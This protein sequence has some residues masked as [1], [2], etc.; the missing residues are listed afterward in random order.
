VRPL[1]LGLILALAIA[2]QRPWTPLRRSRSVA[3]IVGLIPAI[4]AVVQVMVEGGRWQLAP[5]WLAAGV[6][7]GL[8]VRDAMRPAHRVEEADDGPAYAPRRVS[9]ILLS[10]AIG[11]GAILAWGLPVIVLPAPDGP[12]AVGTTTTVLVDDTRTETYGSARGPRVLP[13]QVWYP[14]QGT[15]HNPPAPWLIDREDVARAAA[16]DLGLPGFALDHLGLVASNSLLDAAPIPHGDLPIVLYAH[17]WSGSREIHSTQLESLAS[18]GYLVI[19]ADHTYGSLAT[20]LPDGRVAALDD[21]ALPSGVPQETY[22]EA[23]VQLIETFAA[24]LEAILAAVMDEGLLDD[25]VDAER[26]AGL[27]VGVLGHST[28]GGAA[29][30]A[31]SRDP[32]CG[33][34]VGYDPW[35]EPVPDGVVGGDLDIPLLSVRSEEWVGNDNDVRLRRLHAGS[36]AP[37]GRVMIS[38]IHHRDLTLLPLLSPLSVRLGMSGPMADTESLGLLDLWTVRFLDHH[39][40][41]V[42]PD[43]LRSPPRHHHTTLEKATDGVNGP[44]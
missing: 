5:L 1:E 44:D 14:A 41:G 26:F 38:G 39:L 22:D 34:I 16:R 15:G 17:G 21:E 42:G 10:L 28:G 19:A 8:G 27:P 43:P 20:Q 6:V 4:I 40:R 33:A 36:S 31:C 12:H 9:P 32:R 11:A 3:L 25:L 18:R 35:V 24:D 13:I 30:L 2:A 7:L 37:E 23:A 29:V